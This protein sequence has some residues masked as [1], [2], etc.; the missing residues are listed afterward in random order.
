MLQITIGTNTNRRKVSV[1]PDAIVKNVLD[2]HGI[3]YTSAT[4]HLDGAPLNATE[5]NSSF[6]D[7]GIDTSCY[8]IAVVKA[9]NA[10]S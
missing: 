8:L 6:N 4:V 2:E 10:L 9:E 1:D 5:L 3:N 7:L